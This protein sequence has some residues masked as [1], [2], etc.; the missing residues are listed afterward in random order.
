MGYI[1]GIVIVLLV[2]P[3]LFMLL[4]RRGGG[5]GGIDSS[6]RG[7][8]PDRPAA[9]EPTPRAGPGVDPHVNPS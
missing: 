8:T 1:L 9:D 4:S 3:L 2:L 7:V 5:R 6:N